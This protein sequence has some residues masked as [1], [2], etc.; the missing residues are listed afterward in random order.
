LKKGTKKLLFVS[1]SIAPARATPLPRATDKSFLLLFFKKEVLPSS[2]STPR[3]DAPSA[4]KNPVLQTRTTSPNARLSCSRPKIRVATQHF[5]N[6]Q[7]EMP[8]NPIFRDQFV[9]L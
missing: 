6:Y 9:S 7:Y 4:P 8:V 3:I 2:L 5:T 1:G